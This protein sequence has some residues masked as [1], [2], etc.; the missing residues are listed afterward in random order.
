MVTPLTEVGGKEE[1]AEQYLY[2]MSCSGH[3]HQLELALHLT[4]RQGLIQPAAQQD[5]YTA[6][7]IGLSGLQHPV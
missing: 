6:L 2:S 1:T 3:Q 7:L 4:Y 5:G